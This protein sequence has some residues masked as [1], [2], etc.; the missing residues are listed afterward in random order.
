[1]QAACN[2]QPPLSTQSGLRIPL[3]ETTVFARVGLWGDHTDHA[4][5]AIGQDGQGGQHLAK[6]DLPK[7]TKLQKACPTHP[8]R[9]FC[10]FWHD[11]HAVSMVR[12]ISMD[13]MDFFDPC[14]TVSRSDDFWNDRH[15]WDHPVL[16]APTCAYDDLV[17]IWRNG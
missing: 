16:R 9:E 4:D 12:V 7:L 1:M 5:R 11:C 17:T 15:G 3:P 2:A 8:G 13:K 10:R 6:K 14:G